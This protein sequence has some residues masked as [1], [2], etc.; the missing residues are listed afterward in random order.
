LFVEYRVQDDDARIAADGATLLPDHTLIGNV[1]PDEATALMRLVSD[2]TPEGR[3][4]VV[5]KDT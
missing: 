3:M 2:F 4:S 1:D 5:C